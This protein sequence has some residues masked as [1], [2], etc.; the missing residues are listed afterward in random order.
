[1]LHATVIGALGS[2]ARLRKDYHQARILL[3]EGVRLNNALGSK[4]TVALCLAILGA[5][6]ASEDRAEDAARLFGAAEAQSASY[7]AAQTRRETEEG[8]ARARAQLGDEAF[9]AAWAEG[10]SMGVEQALTLAGGMQTRGGADAGHRAVAVKGST[11]EHHTPGFPAGL[12]E[13]EVDVLRL[14]S[15]GLTS[16]QIGESLVISVVTVNTHLRNIY[17]K[18]GVNSRSAA[19]RWAFEHG[20]V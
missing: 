13:R 4:L 8:V 18:L 5:V 1:M 19:T 17:S 6:A 20:L 10:R 7:L 12:T 2:L 14:L 16:A 11:T 15:Q 9:A 3:S